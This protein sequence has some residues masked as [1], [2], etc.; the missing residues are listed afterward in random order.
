[1]TMSKCSEVCVLL[2]VLYRVLK[3]SMSNSKQRRLFNFRHT[4]NSAELA[5]V[6]ETTG[7][8]FLPNVAPTHL[9]HLAQ[10]GRDCIWFITIL[11]ALLTHVKAA[12]ATPRG[13][14]ECMR[15]SIIRC[16]IADSRDSDGQGMSL[17]APSVLPFLPLYN[18]SRRLL[19]VPSDSRSGST[20]FSLQGKHSVVSKRTS[21]SDGKVVGGVIGGGGGQVAG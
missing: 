16:D 18:T 1:M 9:T 10:L 4:C 15:L 5:A 20:D 8:T 12:Q 17:H 19:S 11:Q 14:N 21:I 3:V 6:E 2:V 13:R 7:G